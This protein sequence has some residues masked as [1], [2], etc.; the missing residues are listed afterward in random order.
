MKRVPVIVVIFLTLASA[1]YCDAPASQDVQKSANLSNRPTAQE[2]YKGNHLTAKEACELW[3]TSPKAV[4]ILDV[5]TPEEYAYAGHAFTA[6]NIPWSI[7]TG[8]WNPESKELV[9]A[10]N[11]NFVSQVKERFKSADMILVMCRSGERSTEPVDRL[12]S[13]G[14]VNIYSVIDGFEGIK[15]DDEGS[16]VQGKRLKNGWKNCDCPWTCETDISYIGESVK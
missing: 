5:R 11:P 15:A 10:S 16:H 12:R 8:S 7:W 2:V 3:K 1:V 14:F 4:N 9:L 13:E 6:I